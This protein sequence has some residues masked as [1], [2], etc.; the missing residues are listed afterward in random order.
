M[1]RVSNRWSTAVRLIA[2]CSAFIGLPAFADQRTEPPKISGRR[3]AFTH[4]SVIDGTGSP[5]ATDQTI[6]LDGDR[7]SM[8]GPANTVAVP[9]DTQVLDLRGH[10]IIPGLVGMHDHLFYAVDG[11]RRQIPVARDFARLYLASGVTSIRTTGTIN[12]ESDIAIKR[13]IDAGRESGPKIHLTSPY[14]SAAPDLKS[15]IAFIETMPPEVTSLKA[16]TD[17]RRDELSTVIGV[18]HRKGLKV[19]GHLC[20]VGF[21][22]AA[23]LGIDNL[24][25]GVIV[26]SEFYSQKVADQCPPQD[27]SVAELAMMGVNDSRIQETLRQL[28]ERKV[29]LTSTLAVFE[30]FTDRETSTDPRVEPLLTW[31][32]RRAYRAAMEQRDA[33]GQGAVWRKVLRTEMAFER[34]FV[35]LGGLLMA[36][37]DPTGWGGVLAGYGDQRNVELLVEAGFSVEHAIQIASANGAAFLGESARIGTLAPG[38]QADLVILQGN[39]AADVRNIRNVQV[40]FENGVAFDPAALTLTATGTI[41][42]TAWREWLAGGLAVAVVLVLMAKKRFMPRR[43]R[44]SARSQTPPAGES[45]VGR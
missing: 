36:G 28:V 41:G 39:L 10:T 18:A 30:S 20:A 38:K 7:I 32:S 44:A 31:R 2:V 24:E 5:M 17:L 45:T 16:Y 11:G 25:H 42:E 35:K 29:A 1:R 12:L 22:Q 34:A 15:L 8:I 6:L 14:L 23:A 33:A 27:A 43:S 3:I 19:T 40:V 37:S 26:D 9:P 21:R 4:T 13:A